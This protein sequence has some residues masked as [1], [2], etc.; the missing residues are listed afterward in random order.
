MRTGIIPVHQGMVSLPHGM[1]PLLPKI[2]FCSHK[3]ILSLH[4]TAWRFNKLP[5]LFSQNEKA[6]TRQ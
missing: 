1:N 3:M 2:I 5:L 6:E 4:K